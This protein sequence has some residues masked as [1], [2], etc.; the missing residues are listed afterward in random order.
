MTWLNDV[1]SEKAKCP[2]TVRLGGSVI[3]LNDV[4]SKKADAPTSVSW[5]A[6]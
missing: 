4:H 3:S 6:A 5:A 2:V 1:H